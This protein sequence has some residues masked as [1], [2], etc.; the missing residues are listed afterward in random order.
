MVTSLVEGRVVLMRIG[1]EER[2]GSKIG[3]VGRIGTS[4]KGVEYESLSVYAVNPSDYTGVSLINYKLTGSNYLTWSR[5]MLTALTTKNKVGMIDGTVPRPSEDDPN[6]ARWDVCNALVI[7]WIFNT[8]DNE[9]Q[10]SIACA[11]VAQALWED[12][13]ERYS[14]GNETRIYQLKAE[15]GNMKQEGMSVMKYYSRLKTLWDKL[16]NYL[17]ILTCTCAAAKLYTT[18]REREKTHQF[19]MG[20]GFEFGTVRSDILSHESAH[21]LNK[22]YE[23]ILHEERQNIVALSHENAAP[24]GAMLLS[25]LSGFMTA[26]SGRRLEWMS[27]K[28]VC[29]I[30]GVWLFGSRLIESS[31]TRQVICGTYDSDIHHDGLSSMVLVWN[32]MQL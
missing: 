1:N 11:T 20:L 12:L 13:Q 14:Q 4:G 7:S 5:A 32:Q 24:D 31:V 21:P 28:E 3:G 26:P 16:D 29:T 19:P 23:M 9:L 30:Y 6:R 22:V 25:K 10:S 8:L 18:Q 17:E 27:S 2:V 15:I